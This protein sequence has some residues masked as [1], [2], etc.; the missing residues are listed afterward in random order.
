MLTLDQIKDYNT[1]GYIVLTN[2]YNDKE[3]EQLINFVQEIESWPEEKYKW[4]KYYE[5]NKLNGQKQLC[6]TENFIEYHQNLN[7][8]LRKK[9]LT[10]IL[11]QLVG[12]P[13]YLYKDKINFKYPGGNGFLPHQDAPAFAAHGQQNHVTV[14]IAIDEA[15]VENGCLEFVVNNNHIWINKILLEHND[16]GSIKDISDF[17][18]QPAPLNPGDI[19][20][21]GSYIPHRSGPNS[22]N[23]SRKI[24]YM[25]YNPVT[26]GNKHCQYYR[27]KRIHFPPDN[28]K[29]VG[30]DYAAGA[31]IY[32][33][34]NPILY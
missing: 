4:M 8:L 13:V 6:R 33:V 2:L 7:N 23:K 1:K 34:A 10:E 17:T 3:K 31:K 25:T 18:W 24:L 16:N 15:T 5:I 11:A 28:E 26:E 27:D 19:V 14:L 29:E 22:T 21:F 9:E 32:N 30:K 12:E 20:I